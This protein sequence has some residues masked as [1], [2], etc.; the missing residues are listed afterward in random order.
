MVTSNN[1]RQPHDEGINLVK[2]LDAGTN[3]W[4]VLH[5]NY[6]SKTDR[7]TE[8]KKRYQIYPKFRFFS[9]KM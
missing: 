7:K 5:G 8:E 1:L 4:I 2:C 6:S 3:V 9:M